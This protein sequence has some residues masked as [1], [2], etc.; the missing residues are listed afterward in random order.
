MKKSVPI[1]TEPSTVID[2]EDIDLMK[3]RVF[4]S[5]QS[6]WAITFKKPTDRFHFL[7]CPSEEI[8]RAMAAKY[9][10]HIT[11]FAPGDQYI[12]FCGDPI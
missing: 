10:A 2:P 7:F 11:C 5:A 12:G 9:G 6:V 3:N 8:A 4:E 1:V